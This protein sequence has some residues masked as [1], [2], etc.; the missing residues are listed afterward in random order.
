MIADPVK[1]VSPALRFHLWLHVPTA[2][3]PS[4]TRHSE[5]R[6]WQSQ[7]PTVGIRAGVTRSQSDEARGLDIRRTGGHVQQRTPA[8]LG[9]ARG[10]REKA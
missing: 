6:R 4:K 1:D 2:Q 10:V 9:G 7:P 5:C 8:G 3:W